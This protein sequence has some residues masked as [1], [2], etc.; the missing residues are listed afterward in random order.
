[1]FIMTQHCKNDHD[2]IL[3]YLTDRRTLNSKCTRFHCLGK[4]E[5]RNENNYTV[6]LL[7]LYQQ[8]L[9]VMIN[10]YV[11][12]MKNMRKIREE[13]HGPVQSPD[14]LFYQLSFTWC[15]NVVR[16]NRFVLAKSIQILWSIILIRRAVI[17]D[18]SPYALMRVLTQTFWL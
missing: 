4:S 10:V 8:K 17:Q 7:I 12:V 15:Q 11:S 18:S 13:G 9:C 5:A 16:S 2:C 14:S 6:Q 3:C 1:M